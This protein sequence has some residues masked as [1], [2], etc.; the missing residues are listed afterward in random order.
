MNKLGHEY[1][2]PTL[3]TRQRMKEAIFQEEDI[4]SLGQ[5][6]KNNLHKIAIIYLSISFNMCFGCSKERSH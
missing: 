1:G 2:P 3:V 6:S 4:Y 5:L